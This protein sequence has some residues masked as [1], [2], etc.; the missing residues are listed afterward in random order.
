MKDG[1]RE[2]IIRKSISYGLKQPLLYSLYSLY[3]IFISDTNNTNNIICNNTQILDEI[4]N[5]IISIEDDP[6]L[7][8]LL[9]DPIY[10]LIYEIYLP[11]ASRDTYYAN[12][13][14]C[15]IYSNFIDIINNEKILSK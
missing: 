15:F 5:I 14:L 11:E 4:H 3:V 9:Y 6:Y 2:V 10:Y 12:R 1:L 13:M 8:S 7:K